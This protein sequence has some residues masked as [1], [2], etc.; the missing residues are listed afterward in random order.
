MNMHVLCG[1][2]MGIVL[3]GTPWSW[4]LT[5]RHEIPAADP[6]ILQPYV[7]SVCE[8]LRGAEPC[9]LLVSS[10]EIH[11]NCSKDWGSGLTRMH[12]KVSEPLRYARW[13]LALLEPRQSRSIFAF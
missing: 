10:G 7:R 5:S 9:I 2:L 3:Q 11:G 4:L 1:H 8:K 13:P 12:V 6:R